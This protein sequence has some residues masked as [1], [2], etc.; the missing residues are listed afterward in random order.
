MHFSGNKF[1]LFGEPKKV[2]VDF[3]NTGFW[4]VEYTLCGRQ[5][6]CRMS[7]GNLIYRFDSNDKKT[8]VYEPDEKLLDHPDLCVRCRNKFKKQLESLREETDEHN[9]A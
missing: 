8:E 2:K 1:H 4:T 5:L 3:T 9:D 6:W 7:G